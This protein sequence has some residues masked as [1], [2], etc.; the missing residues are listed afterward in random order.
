MECEFVN[1]LL[2]PQWNSRI[3]ERGGATFF[4]SAEWAQVLIETYN[5]TPHYAVFK[6]AGRILGI[7]PVMEVRSLWTGRRGVCLP[8]CDECGPLLYGDL[9][10]PEMIGYVK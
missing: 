5:Y 6:Q 10:L 9:A 4:H 2:D 8:F 1:P 3:L 7:L